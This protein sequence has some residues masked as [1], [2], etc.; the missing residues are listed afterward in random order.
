MH[1]IIG[2]INNI[3]YKKY[4]QD[5]YNYVNAIEYNKHFG[6]IYDYVNAIEYKKHMQDGVEYLKY[7]YRKYDKHYT[8]DNFVNILIIY[9]L[10]ITIVSL[11]LLK[12]ESS[13]K[14]INIYLENIKEK[15][16]IAFKRKDDVKYLTAHIVFLKN[17]IVN[18]SEIIDNVDD[19]VSK[20]FALI[21]MEI[22][23]KFSSPRN[24]QIK[25]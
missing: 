10:F 22:I 23:K 17:K 6:T 9:G 20:K 18:I 1:N 4:I 12:K 2:I 11:W 24:L 15:D 7:I 8:Y 21:R 16:D 5:G 19:R 13:K 14:T 25:N 3:E